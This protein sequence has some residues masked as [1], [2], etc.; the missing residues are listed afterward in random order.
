VSSP[1]A[2]QA[3]VQ[4][5]RK[6][7]AHLDYSASNYSHPMLAQS[8][9]LYFLIIGCELAFWLI[10]LL[11]L[12]V[13]Y[14]LRRESVSRWLLLSMPLID[15]L[16]LLFTALDLRAGTTATLAHG[17]AAVYVGFTVAFG[18]MA[19]GWAD[20]H[21]AYR[22]ASGPVPAKAPS[23]GWGVVRFDLGLWLRCIGAWVIA[24]AS[25]EAL[26]AYVA[27][28][29]LTEPL[30]A[31]Y[32]HGFGCVALWFVFGPVWSLFLVRKGAS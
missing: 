19:V 15:G 16:L 1:A 10:L 3:V 29:A 18:S 27:N 20:A 8:A 30:L 6:Q 12:A 28:N 24:L 2:G 17:L 26:I 25:I 9:L 4:L 14:L 31:W 7:S 23:T 32:K 13:R 21:F 11:S 5:D 22:F